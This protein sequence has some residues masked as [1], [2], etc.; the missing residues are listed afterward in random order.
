MFNFWNSPILEKHLSIQRQLGD[1]E[2]LA[3]LTEGEFTLAVS[4]NTD[5]HITGIYILP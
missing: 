4:Q 1:L 5:L 3:D 2:R